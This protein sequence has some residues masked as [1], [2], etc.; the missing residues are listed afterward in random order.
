M[1]KVVASRSSERSI[2]SQAKCEKRVVCSI[3]FRLIRTL[4]SRASICAFELTVK[5]PSFFSWC[6]A[7][8]LSSRA[9][10]APLP[11]LGKRETPCIRPLDLEKGDYVVLPQ[12]K[13][14][15]DIKFSGSEGSP[16]LPTPYLRAITRIPDLPTSL[17]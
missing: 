7:P 8:L 9:S 10:F 16:D 3:R 15:A 1:K 5:S 17:I 12:R 2:A 13:G 4:K 11:L 14:K 6:L